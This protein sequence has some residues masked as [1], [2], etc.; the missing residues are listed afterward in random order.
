M[1]LNL[2]EESTVSGGGNNTQ[3]IIIIVIFAVVLIGYMF[4]SSRQRKKQAEEAEKKL[5]AITV[6]DTVLTIGMISGVIVEVIDDGAFYVIKTGSE[7]NYGFL[8][9]DARAIYQIFKPEDLI[10][11]EENEV[12]QSED[13]QLEET[14]EDKKDE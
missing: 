1:L 12:Q 5:K 8:K 13:A 4:L 3:T 7:E 11:A 14:Q 2:L 9:I 10:K 6:G